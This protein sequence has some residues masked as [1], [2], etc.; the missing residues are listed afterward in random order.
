MTPMID[1]YGSSSNLQNTQN[2]NVPKLHQ[3]S[4]SNNMISPF[5]QINITSNNNRATYM[6][7][8][9]S[10][11]NITTGQG[12]VIINERKRLIRPTTA[13]ITSK[14]KSI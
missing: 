11:P 6:N 5:T 7:N 3:S 1:N 12:K 13:K 14:G 10:V 2:V 9:M 4:A 8:Q